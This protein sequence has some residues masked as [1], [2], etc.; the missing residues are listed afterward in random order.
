[1]F[2]IAIIDSGVDTTHKRLLKCDVS[3]ITFYKKGCVIECIHDS[4]KDEVGHGTSIAAIIHRIVPEIKLVAIKI[5]TEYSKPCEE[6][7]CTAL[8]WCIQQNDIRVINISMGVERYSSVSTLYNLCKQ[9]FE[10]EIII[11]ASS[12]NMPGREC[13][14]AYFPTVYGIT[15]GYVKSKIEYGYIENAPINIIAKGTTQRVACLDGS[16]KITSG[17]SYATAHFT[18]IVAKILMEN[19]I[20]SF[21][22]VL[23]KIKEHATADVHAIQYIRHD[24]RCFLPESIPSEIDG[25]RLFSI[26]KNKEY[27]SKIALFPA[28]EKEIGTIINFKKQCP[29][30]ITIYYDYP[31]KTS[32]NSIYQDCRVTNRIVDSDF[33]NFDTIV[34]GYFLDQMF[35]ANVL[36]GYEL[37]EKSLRCSKNLI[38][39]DRDV[40][41]YVRQRLLLPEHKTYSGNIYIPY[42]DRVVYEETI[43]FNYLPNVSAPVILIVGTSNKQG[44]ITT[45]MRI[46][47]LLKTEGYKIS[48]VSTEPQGLLLGADYVFP[49]GYKT[50]VTINEDL[51]GIF[52][53]TVLKGVNYFHAPDIVITGIQGQLIPRNKSNKD[54]YKKGSLS[55]LHYMTGTL[56]D[57]IICAINPQDTVEQI[58]NVIDTIRIFSNGKLLFFAMTPWLLGFKKRGSNKMI[59]SRRLLSQE[60]KGERMCFFQE[61]LG[62]PVLDIMDSSNESFILECIEKTFT[63]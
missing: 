32:Y 1:M 41:D 56:P 61:Q 24:N 8:K 6:L 19:Q 47:E 30:E 36:F 58:K 9:A 45:Q 29:F 14:P 46:K 23:E 2:K 62:L 52:M 39:F 20:K 13:Y 63:K 43:R 7:L 51:W 40:Y 33:M 27:V 49:Y 59:V 48:H 44:K 35:D 57:A 53:N 55:S 3:G 4:F 25:L 37:I 18:G 16:Y 31:R 17:N 12:H 34:I 21:N 50:T 42:V 10:K 38:L 11:C 15:S 5:A 60:E 26:Q 28:C 54:L 22:A